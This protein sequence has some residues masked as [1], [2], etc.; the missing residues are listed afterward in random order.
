MVLGSHTF[1]AAVIAANTQ[2]L[3]VALHV[4]VIEFYPQR[5]AQV[6]LP[7]RVLQSPP[8]IS[9]PVG[10]LGDRE[11]EIEGSGKTQ[12]TETYVIVLNPN[13]STSLTKQRLSFMKT[14]ARCRPSVSFT[15]TR[16]DSGQKTETESGC[17]AA[18]WNWALRNIPDAPERHPSMHL[19]CINTM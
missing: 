4:F 12:Q 14:S 6:W 3:R 18:L 15:K 13:T 9:E 8:G 11:K 2:P 16:R 17:R 19:F 1:R 7:H 5:P 10:N